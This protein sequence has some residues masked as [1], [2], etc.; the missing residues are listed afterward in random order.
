MVDTC[1]VTRLPADE[2]VVDPVTGREVP[3]EPVEVYAGRCKV[4]SWE[5][6][7]TAPD[8][9]GATAVLQRFHVHVPVTA[10]PFEVG[11]VITITAAGNQPHLVGNEYRVAGRHEK[12]WQ[13]AQR[14]ITDV[15]A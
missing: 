7:E 14:L 5:P 3:A 2:W 10:G 4:Q 1:T 13:T 12:T 9:G 15:G 8:V 6:H 11:D